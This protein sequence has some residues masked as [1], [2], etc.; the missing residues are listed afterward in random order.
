MLIGIPRALRSERARAAVMRS[1]RSGLPQR[2]GA[3]DHVSGE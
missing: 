2:G 1:L 3:G